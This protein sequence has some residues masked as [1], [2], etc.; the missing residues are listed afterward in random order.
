MEA[1]PKLDRRSGIPPMELDSNSFLASTTG[2][3][4]TLVGATSCN[5]T[6]NPDR[7]RADILRA[8]LSYQFGGPVVAAY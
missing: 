4:C 7:F 5:F 6:V 3:G 2:A 8:R 1:G